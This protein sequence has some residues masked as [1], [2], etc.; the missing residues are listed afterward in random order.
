METT[1]AHS[2]TFIQ[3][4]SDG[5]QNTSEERKYKSNHHN[6]SN[7]NWLFNCHIKV[8]ITVELWYPFCDWAVKMREVVI[9]TFANTVTYPHNTMENNMSG[10]T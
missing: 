7:Y 3:S 8:Q 4:C 9:S 6:N 5:K 10:G 2:L 1:T